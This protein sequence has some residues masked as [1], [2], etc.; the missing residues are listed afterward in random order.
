MKLAP[1]QEMNDALKHLQINPRRSDSYKESTAEDH[2]KET[3]MV[4]L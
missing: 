2:I 4:T 1:P 3:R